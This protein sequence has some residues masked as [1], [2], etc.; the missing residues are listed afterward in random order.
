M[1]LFSAILLTCATPTRITGSW[2]NPAHSSK[3]IRHVYVAALTNNTVART[4]AETEMAAALEKYGVK[5]TKSLTAFPPGN[6]K[7]SV[8]L[9]KVMSYV[10]NDNT[11]AILTIT[12]IRQKSEVRYVPGS[13]GYDPAIR[14]YYYGRFAGYYS[15]WYPYMYD[16][17]YY[18]EDEVYF[19]ESNLYDVS[20]DELVWSAQ[21]KTYNPSGFHP[22]SKEFAETIS[23]RLKKDGLIAAKMEASNAKK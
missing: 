3:V 18:T 7:D 5:V 13:Y 11:D 9:E 17:G 8:T 10:R 16:P 2:K 20:T 12:L 21:S 23:A 15:Y 22:F 6:Q 19:I 4:V 14:Y 1:F